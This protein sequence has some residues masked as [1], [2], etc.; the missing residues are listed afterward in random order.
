MPADVATDDVLSRA[1]TDGLVWALVGCP[2][3]RADGVV[4]AH[5]GRICSKYR[6]RPP[7]DENIGV[8]LFFRL[9][10]I[11]GFCGTAFPSVVGGTASDMFPNS[12]V[13]K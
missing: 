12:T 13:A 10:T 1:R 11:T 7:T 9:I 2:W 4:W 8:F 3:D 6:R 5:V